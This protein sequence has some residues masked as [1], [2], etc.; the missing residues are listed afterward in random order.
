MRGFAGAGDEILQHGAGGLKEASVARRRAQGEETPAQPIAASVGVAL[1]EAGLGEGL[2][3]PGNLALLPS[4]ELR[5]ANHAQ[6]TSG[7]SL[8]GA[9]RREDRQ[10]PLQRRNAAAVSPAGYSWS[11]HCCDASN[12]LIR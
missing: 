8:F 7:E 10:T 1:R 2:E 4:H 6:P 9:Q 12:M 5:D 11:N 3:G